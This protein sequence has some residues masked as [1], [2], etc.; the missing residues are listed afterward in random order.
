MVRAK[1]SE[2][3]KTAKTTITAQK[4]ANQSVS[5]D[6]PT[7]SSLRRSFS[8]S[9][10]KELKRQRDML[11]SD[12]NASQDCTEANIK[13]MVE[14][15]EEQLTN[16]NINMEEY[17]NM[18]KQIFEINE[19]KKIREAERRELIKRKGAKTL[20]PND[21]TPISDEEIGF[22]S[23][24]DGGSKR[25]RRHKSDTEK[26]AESDKKARL[27]FKKKEVSE[28]TT[29]GSSD[30]AKIES[31]YAKSTAA[32]LRNNERSRPASGN[33]N[34]EPK[35]RWGQWTAPIPNNQSMPTQQPPP[36]WNNN[37]MNP[38]VPLIAPPVIAGAP[39]VV[40]R[41]PQPPIQPF[42]P[43]QNPWPNVMAN[44]LQQPATMIGPQPQQ[45]QSQQQQIIL[46]AAGN[47]CILKED[48]RTISIDQVPREIRF[49]DDIAIAFMNWDEPKE[50]GF[51]MGKRRVTVDDKDTIVLG[52]NE[53]YKNFT[54]ENKNYEIR[55]GSPTREL[56]INNKWYECYFGDP[57]IGILL[58][59]KVRVFKVE[60]PAPAVKI[61]N[62]RQDLVVG[63]I[64]L[65]IDAKE[66]VPI[67]LD[68][69]VQCFEI[70]G[71]I[72]TLQ[73]ADYLLT[74]LINNE[75]MS[76]EFGGLPKSLFVRGQKH[77]V[78]FTALPDGITPGKA[79]IRNMIRTN[80]HRDVVSPPAPA[81]V[82]L[83]DVPKADPLPPQPPSTPTMLPGL[84]A[85]S[86]MMA[87]TTSSR[88]SFDTIKDANTQAPVLP[89]A[90]AA[91]N[92]G[93]TNPLVDINIGELYQ[94]LLASGI[95]ASG[96]KAPATDKT[97]KDDNKKITPINLST[98]ETI[99]TYALVFIF[100]NKSLFLQSTTQSL[101]NKFVFFVFFS[102]TQ[103]AVSLE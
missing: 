83:N 95:L 31:S 49:Y 69:K 82:S 35:G 77:F 16:N 70:D 39:V 25:S 58:D 48:V 92:I 78:R 46:D 71:Q 87:N 73:F 18:I 22:S 12:D 90:P 93:G 23:G 6:D 8:K 20:M 79:F 88:S 55:F 41:A 17:G 102:H 98:P 62:L 26:T 36:A 3:S 84:D 99:K 47:Q 59:C 89:K 76:V 80:L 67:F 54:I 27:R 91:V 44:A 43:I 85:L 13:I 32:E 74:V 50:I 42:I 75:P 60:G 53:P 65:I 15:A 29:L 11:L 21:L 96:S 40:A 45:V 97:I 1:L 52:F 100:L 5:P 7:K 34:S 101:K 57:P 2:V 56:Y 63:R 81:I 4:P 64:T 19:S 66:T 51:Q 33:N 38:T 28:V 37:P 94:K 30:G 14:Q 24:S 72:N 103:I 9:F 68:A 86:S 61:G 10:N